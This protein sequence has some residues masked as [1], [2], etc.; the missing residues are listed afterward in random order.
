MRAYKLNIEYNHQVTIGVNYVKF[1]LY[2]EDLWDFKT[3]PYKGLLKNLF[4]EIIP[5]MIAGKGE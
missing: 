2:G 3:S 5:G 1:H 4:Y